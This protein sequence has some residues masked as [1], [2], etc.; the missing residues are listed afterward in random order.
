[1]IPAFFLQ[2]FKSDRFFN[3]FHDSNSIFRVRWNQKGFRAARNTDSALHNADAH[4]DREGSNNEWLTKA[5][6]RASVYVLS[7]VLWCVC[8]GSGRFGEN[9]SQSH[10]F[11][12]L[13]EHSFEENHLVHV[14]AKRARRDALD[15]A[16]YARAMLCESSEEKCHPTNGRS[17]WPKMPAH[18]KIE[19][20]R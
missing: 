14:W 8:A 16:E 13:E 4:T 9:R 12:D 20:R 5:K 18:L 7:T 3:Y 11:H 6:Q 2:M 10:F 17:A 1:M 15:L 19:G